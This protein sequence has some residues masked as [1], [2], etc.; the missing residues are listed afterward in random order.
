MQ[1][2]ATAHVVF[3]LLILSSWFST[4]VAAAM[5]GAYKYFF[6]ALSSAIVVYGVAYSY[7]HRLYVGRFKRH[8]DRYEYAVCYQCAYPLQGLP[9]GHQC[10]ECG[11]KYELAKTR[12]RWQ[13]WLGREII[14]E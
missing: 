3:A 4:A 11:S 12:R 6:L 9:D 13:R 7:G 1:L 8:L 2:G 10:P 14:Y 5:S